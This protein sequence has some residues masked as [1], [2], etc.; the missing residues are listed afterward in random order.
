MSDNLVIVVPGIMGTVLRRG[1]VP[2]WDTSVSAMLRNLT[3]FASFTEQLR[4]PEDL[5][6]A[7]PEPPYV[8]EY[9]ELLRGWHVWPGK[10]IGGGYHEFVNW[11][12]KR[13]PAHR[14]VVE[15]GYDWRL[16]IRLNAARLSD[17]TRTSL[18]EWR[19]LSGR[20]DARAVLVCHSMGGLIARYYVNCLGDD[21]RVAR[22]V[23]LG[24]P[25]AGSVNTVRTLVGGVRLVPD[26]LIE[27][28]L[29][30]PSVRQLLPTF[31]CVRTPTGMQAIGSSG[32]PGISSQMIQDAFTLRAESAP[33]PDAPPTVVLGGSRHS[34][35]AG[36]Q[37]APDCLV[38]HHTWLESSEDGRYIEV[39]HGGDATVPR[40]AAVPS[41]WDDDSAAQ[42]VSTRHSRLVNDEALRHRVADAVDGLDP[43]AFLDR[44]NS[45]GLDLPDVASASETVLVR[46]F[47]DR[48]DLRLSVEVRDLRGNVL[49]DCSGRPL[50][51][52]GAGGYLAELR[53]PEGVWN[54]EA[55]LSGTPEVRSGDVIVV[56][57]GSSR[58]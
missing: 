29:T 14:R 22:I 6:D 45:F 38:F 1:Q 36:V 35:I 21:H 50:N 18:D 44:E 25:F 8:L 12:H 3:T 34:T 47:A 40:F 57:P 56:A 42:F 53:L 5:G 30:F 43:R 41:E 10:W 17:F 4:L 11:L 2:L 19:L 20:P 32:L 51:A 52:D 49:S 54:V 58:R 27:T 37:L 31:R 28:M 7:E 16:S 33:H 26:S 39:D 46:A 13:F 48:E 24:T 23:T 55:V 9:G 15:F